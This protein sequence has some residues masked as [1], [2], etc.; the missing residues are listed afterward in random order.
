[1]KKKKPIYVETFIRN[2]LETVWK[3]SQDPELHEQWD[4]RFSE[5][6][7]LPKAYED[8]PQQFLYKTNIGFGMSISGTGESVGKSEEQDEKVSS[9]KFWTQHPLSLIK[10]GSGY[11][12]YIDT[13]EGTRFLTLYNY[14]PALG[15]F[16]KVLDLLFRP[17]L[18][19]ATAWSFDTFRLWLDKGIPPYLS[20]SRS[21]IFYITCFILSFIWIY[22][23][24]VPKILFQ[25]TGELELV[26]A[27]GWFQGY[28]NVLLY[29]LG[30]IQILF[31]LCFLI[32]G[33]SKSLHIINMIALL[34]LGIAAT[35]SDVTTLL[36]PFNTITLTIAMIGL[37]FI[38]LLNLRDLPNASAC[39]R[40]VPSKRG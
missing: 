1:M 39:I 2:D 15:L 22:Q 18:G 9:L 4:L 14:N 29:L 5:I 20:F 28:E 17:L 13:T 30:S 32:F 36:T 19:W 6:T 34:L 21:F 12:K 16:G 26:Q 25:H 24:L 7:Y 38:S 23:G 35:I 10:E 27:T 37:S 33:R 3:F 8:E 31:G 11:W 40:K